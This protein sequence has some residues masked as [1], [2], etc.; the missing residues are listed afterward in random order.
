MHKTAEMVKETDPH[1]HPFYI[2]KLAGP[3]AVFLP[4][5]ER[6]SSGANPL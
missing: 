5:L 6:G 1:F 4:P 2:L 3:G